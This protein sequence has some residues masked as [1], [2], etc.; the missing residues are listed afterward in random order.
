[1]L[2]R[3]ERFICRHKRDRPAKARRPA[4]MDA[5]FRPNWPRF[6]HGHADVVHARNFRIEQ[7]RDPVIVPAPV[8]DLAPESDQAR[9]DATSSCNQWD[10]IALGFHQDKRRTEGNYQDK[11]G[12]DLGL[13]G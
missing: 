7:R 4:Q 8:N 13:E 2:N 6:G 12:D 11:S 1:M 9:G 10:Q 5:E 3:A